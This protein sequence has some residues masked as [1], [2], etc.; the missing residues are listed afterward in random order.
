MTIPSVSEVF[1]SGWNAVLK[2]RKHSTHSMCCKC[3]HLRT[4]IAT[5]WPA[6]CHARFR[7]IVL[8][9]PGEQ[10]KQA[11][12]NKP[13]QRRI[14]VKKIQA[15]MDYYAHLRA[16]YEDRQ[17]YWGLRLRAQCLPQDLSSDGPECQERRR[18]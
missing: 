16:Q 14:L 15:Q 17:I 12:T 7:L 5:A 3:D 8:A 4:Q 1:A 11:S 10:D 13:A 6:Q 9:D 18:H 2:F